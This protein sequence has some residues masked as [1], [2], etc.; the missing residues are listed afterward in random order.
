MV[1]Y[2]TSNLFVGS[3][4][5]FSL[6]RVSL[7]SPPGI[8]LKQ[9]VGLGGGSINKLFKQFDGQRT[10]LVGKYSDGQ[11][12]ALVGRTFHSLDGQRTALV[13]RAV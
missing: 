11:R 8:D 13:D 5:T 4:Q 1:G 10:A 7:R 3:R 9:G 2:T 12:K 6:G